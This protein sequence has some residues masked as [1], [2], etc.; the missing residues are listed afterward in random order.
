MKKLILASASVYRKNLLE[1]LGLNFECIPADI[2]EDLYKEKI[3]DPEQLVKVLAF[4]KAKVV[5]EQNQDAIIIGSDQL[6]Y[7][8]NQVLGKTGSFEASVEQLKL[9]RNK[10]HK[11]LTAFCIMSSSKIVEKTNITTLKMKNLSDLQIKNYLSQDNPFDC[12]GSYKLELRGISLFEYID[13][14]DH[15]A[16]IG[17]PLICVG[18]ELI[19]FGLINP[20]E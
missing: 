20:P 9:L 3:K 14:T 17:L 15:T 18:Q 1:R 7:V 11:L 4:E 6:A 5:F 8:N 16:I 19:K 2:D 12:A 13:T 10:E